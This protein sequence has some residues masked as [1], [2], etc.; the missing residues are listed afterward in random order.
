MSEEPENK[1]K[2]LIVGKIVKPHGIRGGLKVFP[3]TEDRDRFKQLESIYL[4]DE[5]LPETSY[6]VEQVSYTPK[7]LVVY[8]K[9]INNRNDA[10]ALKDAYLYVSE[11]QALELPEGSFYYYELVGMSVQD[12]DGKILGLVN[13]VVDYPAHRMFV[14]DIDGRDV[15]IPDV[16]DIV[17]KI[18]A[19]K[20]MISIH[21]IEGLLE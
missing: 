17:K 2:F 7:H 16:Q 3:I 10:E 19:Q 8:L 20:R 14:V 15:L 6:T 18:D 9:G 11:E 21:V 13:D 12:Q 5:N 1:S 4:G